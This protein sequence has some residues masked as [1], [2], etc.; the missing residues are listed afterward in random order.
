MQSV[1]TGLPEAEREARKFAVIARCPEI[2]DPFF[3]FRF[4]SF[5]KIFFSRLRRRACRFSFARNCDMMQF[6]KT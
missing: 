1:L 6:R 2:G 5:E 4:F 3:L